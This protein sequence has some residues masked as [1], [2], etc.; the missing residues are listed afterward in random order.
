MDAIRVVCVGYYTFVYEG[1]IPSF[2][3]RH[4]R[5]LRGLKRVTIKR[6]PLSS[7]EAVKKRCAVF[8]EGREGCDFVFQLEFKPS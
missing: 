7:L 4:L 8:L 5:S 3:P 2:E 6:C 1:N